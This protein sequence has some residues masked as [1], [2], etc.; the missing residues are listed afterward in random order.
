MQTHEN[1]INSVIA[2]VAKS[3]TPADRAKLDGLKVV[4]GAGDSGTRGVTYFNSWGD[5]NGGAPAPFVEIC[6]FGESGLVQI[7]GTT[8]HEIGHVCAG[9]GAG[10]KKPW[11]D[12]CH[13]LGLRNVMA[14]GTDYQKETFEPTLWKAIRAIPAPADGAPV[15]RLTNRLGRPIVNKPCSMGIGSNGGKSRGAGSGSRLIKCTCESCGYVAR[16]SQKWID[17]PGAPHCPDHGQM[18]VG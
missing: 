8:I 10:H 16:T 1:Y 11:K 2:I 13:D 4:Y 18:V 9:P 6:A 17:N 3:M 5:G 12:K 15:E 14:A 7:A